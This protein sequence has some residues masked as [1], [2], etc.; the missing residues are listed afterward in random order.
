MC[1]F[2][3]W[4]GHEGR[5]RALGLGE[6]KC[7]NQITPENKLV[8]YEINYKR[9]I[10][11]K[12]VMGVADGTTYVDDQIAYEVKGMKVGLFTS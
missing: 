12:L 2:L 7:S 1:F 10:A 5:G 9:V 4:L 11:G 3:G 8:R 6:M